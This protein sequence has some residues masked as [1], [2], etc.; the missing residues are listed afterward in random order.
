MCFL[1]WQ[2]RMNKIGCYRLYAFP[3]RALSI[4]D[5]NPIDVRMNDPHEQGYGKVVQ[6]LR[7][8]LT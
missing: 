2:Q 7:H 6:K 1:D 5:G 3:Y 8:G 4:P